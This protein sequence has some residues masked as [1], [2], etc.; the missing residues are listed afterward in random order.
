MCSEPER[1]APAAKRTLIDH[2]S[3]LLAGRAIIT[4]HS[5]GGPDAFY[6]GQSVKETSHRQVNTVTPV[7]MSTHSFPT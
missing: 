7:G 3:L 2:R 5:T 1:Y 4:A 6:V